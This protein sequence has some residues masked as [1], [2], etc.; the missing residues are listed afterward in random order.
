MEKD[1]RRGWTPIAGELWHHTPGE[2]TDEAHII[3][4]GGAHVGWALAD[5]AAQICAE[6]NAL[7]SINSALRLLPEPV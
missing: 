3:T 7:V 4:S 5:Y 1:L 6:H 2:T